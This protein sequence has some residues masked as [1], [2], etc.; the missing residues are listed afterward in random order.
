M[1]KSSKVVMVVVTVA[2]L[3]ALGL[4]VT[5]LLTAKRMT[6]PI[7]V[8][9]PQGIS[10][11]VA[12]GHDTPRVI[13]LRVDADN[14]IYWNDG[15]V[16]MEDLQQKMEEE[17]RK[18]PAKQPELRIDANPRSDYETLGRILAQAKNAQMKK[19]GFVQ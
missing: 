8:D 19:I 12:V 9:L 17:V 3:A 1:S 13:D 7:T 2:V 16:S 5:T 11:P 6:Y 10:E 15:L 4:F 18:D 14:R